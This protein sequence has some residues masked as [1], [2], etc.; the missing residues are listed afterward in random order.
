MRMRISTKMRKMTTRRTIWR[1]MRK[2]MRMR[3]KRRRL[4]LP[5]GKLPAKIQKTMHSLP[6]LPSLSK[7]LQTRSNCVT[8]HSSWIDCALMRGDKRLNEL[9]LKF[10]LLSLTVNETGQHIHSK[11]ERQPM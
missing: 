1:T 6:N 11:N 3:T 9:C 10:Q 7:V 2:G 8:H 4:L 5:K